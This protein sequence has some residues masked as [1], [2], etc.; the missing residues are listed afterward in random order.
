VQFGGLNKAS[1][2]I[3]GEMGHPSSIDG[4]RIFYLKGYPALFPQEWS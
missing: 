4:Q 1:L 3:P 2:G